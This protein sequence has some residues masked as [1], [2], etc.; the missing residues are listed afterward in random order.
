[1]AGPW[2]KYA[3]P[4]APSAG[5]WAKYAKPADTGPQPDFDALGAQLAAAA[6]AERP[7]PAPQIAPA[8]QADWRNDGQTGLREQGMSGV[9]EGLADMLGTPVD[10]VTSGI[11]GLAGGINWLTGSQIPA[12]QNP[13][14]GSQSMRNL[15][16][17]TISQDAPQGAA[18][19]YARSIGRE[20]GASAIPVLGMAGSGMRAADAGL[21][22]A[23]VV[24]SGVGA[25]AARD[26]APGNPVAEV[27]GGLAGGYAPI[28][29]SRALTPRATAP[30][31]EQLRSDASDLYETGRARQ[32]ADPAAVTDLRQRID[33]E[34]Q[35]NS[36]I[37]PTGRVMADGNV[38]KF[39]D[40]VEDFDQQAMTP[41]QMQNLRTY[42][43]DA[44][45][46][47]DAGER[48]MGKV[49]LD[50]FDDWRAQHVPEFKEAD[51]LYARAK[52]AED[53]DWRVE[54][55]DRR[56]AS[57]GTG[58]NSVNTA[59]QNIRQIL[60]N[61]KA[62]RGYSAE[63]LLEM[64]RIVRGTPVANALRLGG[65]LSPTSG[66]LPLMANIAGTGIN[67][68]VGVP[69]MLGAYGMK[70]GAEAMTA[71][72]INALSEFIRNGGPVMRQGMTPG[73]TTALNALAV[74]SASGVSN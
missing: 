45:G 13:A 27:I 37:T 25:Q 6:P 62:R 20:A 30:T 51:A 58:G 68:V 21:Q 72:Q 2:E 53:V 74:R 23:S 17:P 65:R 18:Q 35:A 57:T 33:G 31:T 36:R 34:L 38:K 11:N 64:E 15:L 49:L 43:Q 5:P 10:L 67:P 70:S 71:G 54:K 48:R 41:A 69:L 8:K 12:I 55:A 60:D 61:P 9:N 32:A 42:L 19:R 26:I 39:L 59:R 29:A 52:R 40:V 1:M 46:S 56:A 66:A 16:A 7:S 28:A 47:A 50:Q 4:A 3:Q 63:E 24:G 22:A 14:G 44:A 73:Q